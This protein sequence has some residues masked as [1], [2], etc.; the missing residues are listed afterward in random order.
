MFGE[1]GHAYIYL[2]YGVHEMLNLVTAPVGVAEAV[3][4]RAA[5]PVECLATLRANRKLRADAPA[6]AIASGPGKL[7][8]AFEITRALF[9]GADITDPAGKL[10]VC[11]APDVPDDQIVQTTRIGISQGAESPWRYYIR[12]NPAVSRR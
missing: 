7:A 9:N 11:D 12:D 3:L 1:P 10:V 6:S 5:W 4:I 2:S 8:Q